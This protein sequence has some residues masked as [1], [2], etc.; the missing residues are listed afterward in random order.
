M[1]PAAPRPT[2]LDL[3]CSSSLLILKSLVSAHLLFL[4]RCGAMQP[5]RRLRA[6]RH[7]IHDIHETPTR[8]SRARQ[9]NTRK[10]KISGPFRAYQ[11]GPPSRLVLES[12][13]TLSPRTPA[14][15]LATFHRQKQKIRN[16][17]KD[18]GGAAN[19]G[20]GELL[21]RRAGLATQVAQL[22]P[23][24]ASASTSEPTGGA[25]CAEHNLPLSWAVTTTPATS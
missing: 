23:D 5:V 6:H 4:V 12:L 17:L 15:F 2:P 19:L 21:G 22:P 16:L 13:P 18:T 9:K 25:R 24:Q 7:G 11:L 20:E 14:S 8:H 10:R 1:M 3:G